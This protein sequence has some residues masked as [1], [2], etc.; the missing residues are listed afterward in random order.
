M[1]VRFNQTLREV[2]EI[3]AGVGGW[4]RISDVAMFFRV[5]PAGVEKENCSNTNA[6]AT[7]NRKQKG[8][9]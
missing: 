8:M 4:Q 2:R 7:P 5:Q 3:V 6:G 1:K 9:K